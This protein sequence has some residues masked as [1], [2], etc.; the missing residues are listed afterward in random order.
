MPTMFPTSSQ[1]NHSLLSSHFRNLSNYSFSSYHLLPSNIHLQNPIFH[2]PVQHRNATERNAAPRPATMPPPNANPTHRSNGGFGFVGGWF[3]NIPSQPAPAQPPSQAAQQTDQV[4]DT[5][6][7]P[8]ERRRRHICW[9]NRIFSQALRNSRIRPRP[10]QGQQLDGS[11]GSST[12]ST[13]SNSSG[14]PLERTSVPQVTVPVVHTRSTLLQRRKQERQEQAQRAAAALPAVHTPSTLLQH[15]TQERQEK[16]S[17]HPV[18]HASQPR[19]PP[20]VPRRPN[21]R[22][23]LI[24]M[25]ATSFHPRRP[26]DRKYRNTRRQ[27][28]TERDSAETANN[29][30]QL[31]AACGQNPIL[32]GLRILDWEGKSPEKRRGRLPC[33][34]EHL[35]RRVE[36]SPSVY[37]LMRKRNRNGNGEGN[38][39]DSCAPLS[40]L[41]PE[42]FIFP[43]FPST[44][45]EETWTNVP[46]LNL[47]PPMM[48]ALEAKDAVR[49]PK[50]VG[51]VVDCKSEGKKKRKKRKKEKEE[52]EER[53]EER[54][55]RNRGCGGWGNI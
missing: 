44:E 18:H 46:R 14:Y 51:V 21:Y 31:R 52:K 11:D 3:A 39:P 36:T 24:E 27:R 49:A 35:V 38:S 48:E 25:E 6:I 9:L 16:R 54:R 12:P 5:D 20:I 22:A 17:S 26:S 4:D 8:V 55:G 10:N 53:A 41:V 28:R 32:L 43:N 50:R 15:R 1:P 42:A 33:R 19:T 23:K 2:T 34:G 37:P 45:L 7:P 47:P 30:M 13:D 29:A 40:I